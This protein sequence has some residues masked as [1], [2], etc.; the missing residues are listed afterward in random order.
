[1]II[2]VIVL[3]L[4]GLGLLWQA[5]R[6]QRSTGL[7]SGRIIYSD[8]SRW[9]V[10]EKAIYDPQLGLTGR[11]D[12]LV[13]AGEKIIPVEVKSTAVSTMPYDS[14]I[15]QLAAYCLLVERSS[16]KRPDHGILHYPNRTFAIDYTSQLERS[17]LDLLNEMRASSSFK[18]IARS[19]DS[20]ARCNAC[21]YR[22]VCEQRIF[23]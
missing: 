19:H 12:F 15:F 4:I 3:F 9:G 5:S 7:P 11:P 1:M 21:G 20:T 10:Q 17:L 18:D 16:G 23:N 2:L 13:Q 8:T 6:M 22:N 14:H